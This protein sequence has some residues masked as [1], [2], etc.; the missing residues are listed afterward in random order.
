[1]VITSLKRVIFTLIPLF[2][3]YCATRPCEL[4][5][6]R[7][8]KDSQRFSHSRLL[9]SEWEL[10]ARQAEG[11]SSVH[12]FKHDGSLYCDLGS[13][14]SLVEMEEVLFGIPIFSRQKKMTPT[15]GEKIC[16]KPTGHYN[17]YEIPQSFAGEAV[18]RGFSI[19]SDYLPEDQDNL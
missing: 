4:Y 16:G 5:Q 7:E 17:V 11:Q 6:E 19:D 15:L 14:Q 1:M 9:Q 10:R 18:R 3:L 2:N 8:Q 12:V 13:A